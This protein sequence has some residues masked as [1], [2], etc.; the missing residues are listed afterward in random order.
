[1]L[2]E[3]GY[4]DENLMNSDPPRHIWIY[5]N[6]KHY[7]AET[8]NGVNNPWNLPIFEEWNWF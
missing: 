2:D 3:Y 5:Y 4:P 6:N 7:D 1:M 8:H